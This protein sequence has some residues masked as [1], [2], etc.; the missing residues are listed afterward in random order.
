MF[1]YMMIP[2]SKR[3]L[4]CAAMV[5]P[6]AKVADVGCDHGY[7]GIHLLRNCGAAYV[8]ATDLRPLP[9]QKARENAARFGT[10]SCMEFHVSDGLMKIKAGQVDTVV[11][12]GMGG[13]TIAA[14]LGGTP[15]VRDPKIRLILQ[16]QSS[17][18]DLRRWLGENGFSIVQERLVEDGRFLYAVMEVRF[19][20]GVPLSP[21]A[22]YA[23]PQLLRSEPELVRRYLARL[24]T[25]LQSTVAGIA[26]AKDPQNLERLQYYQTALT[27]ITEMR[28]QYENCL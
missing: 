25:S 7:L 26:Q 8:A 19:G 15:W 14:I 12:A 9:L 4:C 1:D 20:G 11:C 17:G 2:I 24:E 3:L 16:P 6:G 28:R 22:Q 23:S 5:P 27:E 21:G 18:N 13:D 10:D